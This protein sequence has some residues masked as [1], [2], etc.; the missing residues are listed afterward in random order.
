M[1]HK[2][3]ILATITLLIMSFVSLAYIEDKA[4]DPN[5]NK[6]WWALSFNDPHDKSLGFTI[7]NHSEDNIYFN[8]LITRNNKTLARDFV[9]VSR[10][11]S[12]NV[13]LEGAK[14]LGK[15]TTTI[16]VWAT[17]TNRKEISK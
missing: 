8:Y 1:H 14:S 17:E 5:L 13:P 16:S 12:E 9:V 10:G 7:E 15:K 3:I 2:Y 6:D 11:S 4:K